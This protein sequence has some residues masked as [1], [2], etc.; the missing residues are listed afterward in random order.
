ML[1]S[2]TLGSGK[3]PTADLQEVSARQRIQTIQ[4]ATHI[5]IILS[6]LLLIG[7]IFLSIQQF[8][9]QWVVLGIANAMTIG[10]GIASVTNYYPHGKYYQ[11]ITAT[12]AQFALALVLTGL[13]ISSLSI[14]MA[15]ILLVF[16]LILSSALPDQRII[17]ISVISGIGLA[18]LIVVISELGIIPQV[19]S[20][21]IKIYT[22]AILAILFMVY[23]V[24]IAM[25]FVTA[26]MRVR[27]V[28]AFI[29]IVV[30][31]LALLS[32]VQ[33]GFTS[34]ALRS[35]TD[36][37]LAIAARQTAS[38]V[39]KFIKDLNVQTTAI[40][41]TDLFIRYLKIPYEKRGGTP[42]EA[43]LRSTLNAL[44][45]SSPRNNT[46]IPSYAL[47]DA[48][49]ID[50]FDT[51]SDISFKNRAD[52]KLDPLFYGMGSF[53]YTQQY[54][55][56]PFTSGNNF[57]SPLLIVGQHRALF[58]Y[59][60]PIKDE[61]NTIVGV[62]R[63]RYD[64][65]ILQQ[66]ISEYTGLIAPNSYAIL[67]DENGVRLAD[68]FIPQYVFKSVAPLPAAKIT[69]LQSERRLPSLPVDQLS[70]NLTDFDRVLQDYQA[71]P[72][73]TLQLNNDP[74]NLPEIGAIVH[75]QGMPWKVAY[76][77]ENY[78]DALVRK[79]QNKAATILAALVAGVVGMI[80][81]GT[82]QLLNRPIQRLMKIAQ[83]I[84][85]GD[86]QAQAPADSTDEFGM[87]GHALNL[88]T[89][90]LN[91]FINELEDRVRARTQEIEQQNTKLSANA[92]QLHTLADV[93]RQ[94]ASMQDLENVLTGIAELVSDRFG[95]YHV[96]IFLLDDN[97]EYAI[98]RASNSEGG[99]RMLA[100]NHMLE[101]GRV[102]IVGNVTST[103]RPRIATDVGTDATYFNNPDLPLTRSEMA[104]PLKVGSQIIG[105]LDIQSTL[106]GA[107]KQEDIDLFATLADQIAIAIY[108]NR[109]YAETARA[110]QEA[111]TL[112]R[113]YLR[114]AWTQET[115][116][117][118]VH[119]YLY[120]RMG[121]TPQD[122]ELPTWKTVFA[123]GKPVIQVSEGQNGA[124]NLASMAVPITV[125]G[126]TIGVV[127]V[128]DQGADRQWST[129]EIAIVEDVAT[130]VAVA[131][132]NA[133]LIETTVRRAEREKKVL[134]ITARIRA[135]N[136]PDRMMQ[137]AINE[138]QQAL[139]ATRTQIY[140]R[141]P[142]TEASVDLGSPAGDVPQNGNNSNGKN[143]RSSG[144]LSE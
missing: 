35:Q 112:H 98:L 88:M 25:Q 6:S 52:P 39:E 74:E 71:H 140:V 82:S 69:S 13:L 83:R 129:D 120:N 70:T 23:V 65:L 19:T 114:S 31:P 54:F 61:N 111:Q 38:G 123:E 99:K 48:N 119:G 47:L 118:P 41:Q 94:V 75:L 141:A 57:V 5:L 27:L 8:T 53:E 135:T 1:I 110:L 86:I 45:I 136:E 58:Y 64:G 85:S 109:L 40:S 97:N 104:L 63:V 26:S 12:S 125:R 113:Q 134:E 24:L 138:L 124:P 100:R 28:T 101:V 103:G 55:Q 90:Q 49:G 50:S 126:E 78:D 51:G 37:E 14:P 139:G 17:D 127:H 42:E 33:E 116:S 7:L 130:Q 62:L 131:L 121:I 22:P 132:E 128:Q 67:V 76:V 93:A 106:S 16:A 133:R 10:A 72:L 9:W 68:A 66:I 34:N 96:G 11:G 59:S 144:Q 95:F 60:V 18:V 84:S 20:P 142:V 4:S 77:L 73:F 102:G 105:A 21:I 30:I 89:G 122:V 79:Q 80:A 107:F 29:A 137:I 117:R 15:I 143:H 92:Q 3:K 32:S 108:N 81:V 91:R 87:L 56:Q 43:D 36:Y 115:A 46:Y 2:D 44:S